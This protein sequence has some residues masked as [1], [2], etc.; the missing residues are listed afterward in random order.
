MVY[1]A[2]EYRD[3][4]LSTRPTLAVLLNIELDHTDYFADIAALESSFSR[5]ASSAKRVFYNADDTRLSQICKDLESVGFGRGEGSFYRCTASGGGRFEIC[6]DGVRL[7]ESGLSILGDF[8]IMNAIAAVSVALE[9]GLPFNG[10]CKALE[11]YRGIPRRLERLGSLC[12]APVLYDYAH[13]PSEISSGIDAVRSAFGGKITVV[14]RPHTYSRTASLMNDFIKALRKADRAIILDVVAAREREMLGADSR[15]LAE[16]IGESAIHVS[17][18][19]EAAE[20][21]LRDR[22]S[23]IIIMGAGDV[24]ELKEKI[25]K[26]LD[27]R[28]TPC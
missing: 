26:N 9:L 6:R 25:E 22:G 28:H 8:N 18:Q 5:F 27:K 23:T 11:E 21:L 20:I 10:I 15:A 13:H 19:S 1:E 24:N 4:F 2:C 7:G 17:S 14:F 12:G 3:A 16:G